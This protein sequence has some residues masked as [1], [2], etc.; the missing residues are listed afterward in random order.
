MNSVAFGDLE[1]GIWGL[2]WGAAVAIGTPDRTA[3]AD[4]ILHA[5][6]ASGD[7]AL[8]G[9]ALEL[10]LAPHGDAFQ[11][12]RG[13]AQLCRVRGRVTLPDGERSIDCLGART[14]EPLPDPAQ[15][16]SLRQVLAWFEP[17][18]GL[19][20]SAARP[21]RARGQESDQVRAGVLEGGGATS[22]IDPRLSTTYAADGTPLR[23]GLE[24]W[25]GEEEGEQ[26]PRRAAGEAIG[27]AV[28][29]DAGEGL[30]I[31]ARLFRWH[32]RGLDGAGVYVL[33]RP[34]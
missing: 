10:T 4:A 17:D 19:A 33:A 21:R 15:L 8:S 25:L 22:V 28:S 6:G 26:Y 29:A 20:L 32:S 27:P 24:L 9:S 16:G 18:L 13:F 7:W 31:D 34:R 23:A 14:A 3:T 2:A 11:D 5:D 1:Q 30:T 12:E